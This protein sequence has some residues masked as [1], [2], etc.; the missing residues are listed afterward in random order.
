MLSNDEKVRL[1][2]QLPWT[3]RRED[4]ADGPVLRVAEFPDTIITGESDE[5]LDQELW[6]GL[7][8]S[9]EARLYFGDAIPLPPG[10]K[11]Y[12]WE[13]NPRL[14]ALARRYIV[15]EERVETID[16]GAITGSPSRSVEAPPLAVA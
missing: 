11:Q 6:S 14:A 7:R 9:I 12:P 15:K 1:L 3:I 10:V 13:E 16:D 5:E 8:A 2:L 4:T